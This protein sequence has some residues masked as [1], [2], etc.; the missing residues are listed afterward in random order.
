MSAVMAMQQ[1]WYEDGKQVEKFKFQVNNNIDGLIKSVNDGSTS[2]FM[3]EWFTTKPYADKGL[4]R[5]IGSVPTP[6][7]SWMVAAHSSAT[8]A[9]AGLVRDFLSSLTEY[10]RKFAQGL[11]NLEPVGIQINEKPVVSG[12]DGHSPNAD[13]I[14]EKFGYPREDVNQWLATVGYPEDVGLVDLTVITQTLE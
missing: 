5:F 9:P 8:R 14:V 6:W 7:P 4:V 1:G 2:A 13:Y 11:Q 3:W 12:A 10:V